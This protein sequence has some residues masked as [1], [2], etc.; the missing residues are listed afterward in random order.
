MGDG[1]VRGVDL[2]CGTP[3]TGQVLAMV[4]A[5]Q[6]LPLRSIQNQ[7][8]TKVLEESPDDERLASQDVAVAKWR[9]RGVVD[10]GSYLLPT[11]GPP[12]FGMLSGRSRLFGSSTI[13]TDRFGFVVLERG[14]ISTRDEPGTIPS[15]HRRDTSVHHVQ[16]LH[17][18]WFRR[19]RPWS[20]AQSGTN[21]RGFHCTFLVIVIVVHVK[22]PKLLPRGG[23]GNTRNAASN[24]NGF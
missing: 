20:F 24:I 16:M 11:F 15:G 3:G 8:I 7:R 14:P 13:K 22:L 17:A 19:P 1:P 18:Q 10:A 6:T 2:R 12:L 9:V 5:T 4:S 21:I 23:D